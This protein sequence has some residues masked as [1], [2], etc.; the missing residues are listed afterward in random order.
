[1]RGCS[2]LGIVDEQI[3]DPSGFVKFSVKFAGGD[4]NEIPGSNLT[5]E[6]HKLTINDIVIVTDSDHRR[7]GQVIVAVAHFWSSRRIWCCVHIR[8]C[9][10]AFTTITSHRVWIPQFGFIVDQDSAVKF[11]V[12]FSVRF[13]GG[14]EDV[15]PSSDI[16][17][18]E[19][20]AMAPRPSLTAVKREWR[21]LLEQ[22]MKTINDR[23][24]QMDL[25]I[26]PLA[27]K[28]VFF[29]F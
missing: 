3:Q 21:N 24:D 26:I 12:R 15:F 22:M 10:Y 9:L 25:S 18:T 23:E 28:V 8:I 20:I 13:A 27:L 6:A 1:M 11:S 2:Q 29:L 5:F 14:H 4:V 19:A 17:F 16:I 7:Y